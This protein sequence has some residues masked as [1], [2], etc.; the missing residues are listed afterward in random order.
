MDIY[1]LG[2][3]LCDLIVDAKTYMERARIDEAIR[4][5]TPT[6]P[7]GYGLEGTAE[8]ELLLRLVEPD[9]ERRPTIQSV[10]QYLGVW[11]EQIN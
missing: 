10:K 3:I 8:G 6:L 11:A 7:R 1:A 9:S 2:I 4:S 5:P